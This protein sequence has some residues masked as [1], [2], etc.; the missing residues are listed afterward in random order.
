MRR[1]IC[2][3]CDFSSLQWRDLKLPLTAGKG[4][5]AAVSLIHRQNQTHRMLSWKARKLQD[6]QAKK[7][8]S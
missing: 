2:R 7:L 6:V 5:F 8:K 3:L 4:D 1:D